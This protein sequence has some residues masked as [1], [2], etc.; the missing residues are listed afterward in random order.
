MRNEHE[1]ELTPDEQSLMDSLPREATPPAALE[2][3]VVSGL[4]AEGMIRTAT[5]GGRRWTIAAMLLLAMSLSF[6]AGS[7]FG[8]TT[9]EP[10][11]A[12]GPTF[13]LLVYDPPGQTPDALAEAALAEATAWVGELVSG[14]S[15]EAAAKLSDN[16]SRV[17]LRDQELTFSSGVPAI[18][19]D[20]VLGGF[21]MIRADSYDDAQ[22]IA[23][24]CP[25]L[26][27]GST[28]EVRAVET[29]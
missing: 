5:G 2:D 16:G 11:A 20:L 22:R 18:G 26:R 3:R 6:F 29:N 7:R 8:A 14:G 4:K 21:F 13:A 10:P 17:E 9:T 23:A 28:I 15:F 24:T 27:Y 1:D 12:T 19:A 25:L